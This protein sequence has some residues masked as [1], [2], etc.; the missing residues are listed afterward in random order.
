[1]EK[2][3]SSDLYLKHKKNVNFTSNES[4]VVAS[5]LFRRRLIAGDESQFFFKLPFG[6]ITSPYILKHMSKSVKRIY[7]AVSMV[8]KILIF[9]D[10]DSDGATSVS[11]LYDFF[12]KIGADVSWFIPDREKDAY[13]LSAE[14]V[15]GQF[16]NKDIDL[17]I[18]VDCGINSVQGVQLA[19]E[20]GIDVIITDHHEVPADLPKAFAIIN[21][22]QKDCMSQLDHLA[23]VGLAYYLAMALTYYF[24]QKGFWDKFLEPDLMEYCDIFAI[25]TLADL[26]PVKGDNK[27]MLNFGYKMIKSVER[28][29]GIQAMIDECGFDIINGNVIDV[30]SN[31]IK[32]FQVA[33]R[34]CHANII[35]DLL[36][37]EDVFKA[38]K[39]A[40]EL[41][42]YYIKWKNEQER[43]VFDVCEYFKKHPDK[44]IK[45]TIVL[46]NKSWHEGV[47]GKAASFLADKFDKPVVLI[48]N[49]N[50]LAKGSARSVK[51]FNLFQLLADNN[52]AK[53]LKEF[54]GHAMAAGIVCESN[55]MVKFRNE[56]EI[57]VTNEIEKHYVLV[58]KITDFKFRDHKPC[59]NRS[60]G[61]S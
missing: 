22:K 11:I 15:A 18:T 27:N 49:K 6:Q 57:A 43:I 7:K 48:S 41:N 25:G 28:R 21:P 13:G 10:Y 55:N 56:F 38:A 54:G 12:K 60:F 32:R 14:I 40:K 50:V 39:I 35:V 61:L 3:N 30:T 31:L 9:G 47:L 42:S 26:V 45:N 44:T 33:G 52:C 58:H 4:P 23:G 37:T 29:A 20:Y 59:E 34:V 53:Y 8:E 16:R 19:A 2:I 5:I 51:G 17:I 24:R 1:M 36:T 46:W